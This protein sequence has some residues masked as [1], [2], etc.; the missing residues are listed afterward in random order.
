MLASGFRLRRA[1]II[2]AGVL[3][4]LASLA[5]AEVIT[6]DNGWHYYVTADGLSAELTFSAP[7]STNALA[8]RDALVVPASVQVGSTVLPV[9]GV[10][11]LACSFCDGLTSVSL[12]EGVTSIGLGAFSDCNSLREVTLPLSLCT[13]HDLSFY[14]DS[15]L[16]EIAIPASVARIGASAFAYCQHLDSVSMQQG[17]RSI[18][19][20]AFYYCASLRDLYIPGSVGAIGEY[21]F[22]YCTGLQQVKM[23]GEPLAI[24]SDVFEGVDVSQCRLVVPSDQVDAYREAEVWS[25]FQIVDGGYED[26]P[27]VSWYADE[28]LFELDVRG[29]EL[30]LNVIGDAPALVYDQM[31][32]RIALAASRSG[33][34]RIPLA[35]GRVY[36]IRCGRVSRTLTL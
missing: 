35:R 12:P 13:M 16:V 11:A 6:D 10:T 7:D 8:Y 33:E 26:L 17:T 2:L 27:E 3:A 23:E 36:I 25:D 14:R 21:A 18:A 5:S 1:K 19:R 34:N 20:Q 29:D 28:Q 15:A 9:T 22:A 30:W 4:T 31:G 24:T 32:R